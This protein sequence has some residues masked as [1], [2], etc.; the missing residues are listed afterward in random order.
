MSIQTFEGIVE[1][2][3]IRL[4]ENIQLS[5][6]TKVYI[7]IPNADTKQS[8]QIYSPQL[9]NKIRW[10]ILKWKSLRKH[11]MPFYE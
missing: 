8:H 11:E 7:V 10:L 1:G 9:V 4:L 6:K 3:Q 5:D 2:G